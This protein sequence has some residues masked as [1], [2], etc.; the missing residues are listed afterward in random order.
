MATEIALTGLNYHNDDGENVFVEGGSKVP[1]DIPKQVLKDYRE[2]GAI[3]EAPLT[4]IDRD[5]E[6]DELLSKVDELQKQLADAQA[7]RTK[8]EAD[9]KAAA[10]KAPQK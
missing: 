5:A 10:N 3:G 1:A 7:A 8:A 4:Q 9:A 2:N 6:K